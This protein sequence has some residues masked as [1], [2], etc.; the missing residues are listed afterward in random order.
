MGND[1]EPLEAT[2]IKPTRGG[3]I[4]RVLAVMAS[5][6]IVVSSCVGLFSLAG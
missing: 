5:S 2:W 1:Q 3:V 4:L 6:A